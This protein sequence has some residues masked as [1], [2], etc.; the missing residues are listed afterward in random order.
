V[1]IDPT[2]LG[3]AIK[4][5]RRGLAILRPDAARMV[6]VT[7]NYFGMLEAGKRMPS[8]QLLN[9]IG[10]AFGIPEALLFC[11]GSLVPKESKFSELMESIQTK[12]LAIVNKEE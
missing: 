8:P 6:G 11:L 12:T 7:S 9:R 3:N 1:T 10:K 2:Q 4:R 5:I